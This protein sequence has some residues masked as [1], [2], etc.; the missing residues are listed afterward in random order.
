MSS[1]SATT[2]FSLFRLCPYCIRLRIVCKSSKY[3]SKYKKCVEG[4]RN[5]CLRRS[6]IRFHQLL[7][8]KAFLRQESQYLRERLAAI[9][10]K[11]T[12]IED[13]KEKVMSIKDVEDYK[14]QK[15]S[16]SPTNNL[17]FYHSVLTDK[18]STS[19]NH[20]MES[21]ELLASFESVQDFNFDLFAPAQLAN[22]SIENSVGKN[23]IKLQDSSNCPQVPKCYCYVSNLF[24]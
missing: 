7:R 3:S 21:D 19:L 15:T 17:I 22:F 6:S 18:V 1:T 2:F 20:L 5:C 16:E 10:D 4:R 12:E 24:T 23:L 14:N 8:K 11:M 9:D 13:I